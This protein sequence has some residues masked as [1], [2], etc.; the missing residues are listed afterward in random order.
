[1]HGGAPCPCSALDDLLVD[2]AARAHRA[3]PR[4]RAGARVR[5]A[6]CASRS[7]GASLQRTHRG[8][9]FA[10]RVLHAGRGARRRATGRPAAPRAR[11]EA[12]WRRADAKRLRSRRRSR[13]RPVRDPIGGI[14]YVRAHLEEALATEPRRRGRPACR[15]RRRTSS[16]ITGSVR[17][18]RAH[19]PSSTSRPR[20]RSDFA[21]RNDDLVVSLRRGR[22]P[23][24]RRMIRVAA[25]GDCHV[26]AD[27][28]GPL[29]TH[30]EPVNEHADVLLVAGDLTK[31][32]TEATRPGCSSMSSRDVA[33]R[34]SRC[35]ATTTTT[36]TRST[37]SSSVLERGRRPRARRR[38]GRR[39][40]SAARRSASPARRDSAAASPARAAA[41]SASRR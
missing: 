34:S 10:A 40:R 21:V 12:H 41:S 35:S 13:R 22:R 30:L 20:S 26:G 17:H 15:G 1:M 14:D 27:T 32:G 31:C 36:P 29:A 4:L 2:Q 5:R 28:S 3:Q 25:F 8:S 37:A 33:S 18:R 39:S 6:A 11:A 24:R 23:T 7:T 16:C 9:P 19:E 38:L